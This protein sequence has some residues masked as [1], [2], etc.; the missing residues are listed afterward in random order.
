M[1]QVIYLDIGDD[2][3]AIR[4]LLEGVQA[5]LAL[6][7][8]PKGY[9]PLRDPLNLRVLRRYAE[10]LALDVALVTRD[11]RTRQ[12]AKEEGIALATSTRQGQRGR[13]RSRSPQRS[14]AEQAA[15]DR[16]AGLRAGRGDT[17]YGDRAIVWAGRLLGLLLSV[18]LLLLIVALGAILVPEAKVTL[19]PFRQPVETTLQLRADPEVS[20]P[21]SA[22][23][24]IP[25]RIVEVQ[26]ERTGDIA[27]ISKKDAPDAPASGVVTFINQTV[28]PQEILT[29][30]LVRTST[31]TTVRFKTVTTATLESGV[32]SRAE[33]QIEAL[34]PGPVGNVAAATINEIETPGLRGKVSVINQAPTEGGGVKLVG[35]VTRVDM[36]RLNVQVFDELQQ[37]AFL[38]LQSQLSEQEFLP[39]E[40]LT[41][42]IMSETYDQ[43]L[44]T[45]ADVLHLQMRILA[46]G[47][48]VDQANANLM[49]YD[50]L[51]EQIPPTYELESEEVSF[52]HSEE[53]RMDGRAV[54]IDVTA[55]A[56]L[57]AD[58]DQSAA[59]SA[60]AGLP[61]DEASQILADS[62]ALD[63]PPQVVV[64][65]D[66]IKRWDWLDR[67]PFPPFRIQVIVL[68]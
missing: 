9:Q 57:V 16:M 42:E 13:W 34:V 62:F 36:D 32:G 21:D 52:D 54:L 33:V 15:V 22:A 3:P 46:R 40:S 64:M 51:K 44:D 56:Q 6:L 61:A 59:R 68:E 10:D 38:E 4:H 53:V 37:H 45:Q 12:M 39:P 67:V 25:A 19:V 17:G 47:T 41:F 65:P 2:L 28:L 58:V 35:V 50:S 20:R 7:V 66:W 14:S 63:A 43:F 60:V 8:L 5:K 26:V 24:T 1:Q 29:S 48:A 55:S 30:T 11:G 27:T 31:G 49:A 18:F 23:L